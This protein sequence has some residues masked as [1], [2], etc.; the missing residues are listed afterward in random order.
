MEGTRNPRETVQK[1]FV[2]RL[3]NLLSKPVEEFNAYKLGIINKN[4]HL[5]H[6]PMTA[7]ERRAY[8]PTVKF[9]LDLRRAL[10][11]KTFNAQTIRRWEVRHANTP[12]LKKFK[13]QNIN[14]TFDDLFTERLDLEMLLSQF[15][16][17]I[18]NSFEHECVTEEQ[19]KPEERKLQPLSSFS[20]FVKK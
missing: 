9:A 3:I 7:K 5:K 15:N 14:E 4:G 16:D 2:A 12:E 10:E 13:N 6:A 19:Q 8:N 18:E 11:T 17:D 20:S 1:V